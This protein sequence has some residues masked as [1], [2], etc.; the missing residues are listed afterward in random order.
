MTCKNQVRKGKW[1]V[2]HSNI[3][4]CSECQ[5]I[6]RDNRYDHINFCNRCGADMR[7]KNE[8]KTS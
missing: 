8:L 7:V 6:R 2:N 4:V 5:G 1:I 3:V